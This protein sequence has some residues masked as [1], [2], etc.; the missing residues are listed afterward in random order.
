MSSKTERAYVEI[1]RRL[2]ECPQL[3]MFMSDFERA[4]FNALTWK[5]PRA[6][7]FILRVAYI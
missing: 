6:Q 5:F 2:P 3:E 4:E 7:V 1:L